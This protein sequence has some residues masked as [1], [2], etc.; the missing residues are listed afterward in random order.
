MLLAIASCGGEKPA[1]ELTFETQ[2]DTTGLS[3]GAPV[4]QEFEPYRMDNGAVRVK[5]R[6]RVPD[7][8]LLQIAIK[9]P[10]GVVSVAM[11]HV[12]VRGQWF[13]TPP[14]LEDTGPLP[15]GPYRFEL[16]SHFTPEWQGAE[17]DG[18]LRAGPSLRGPGITRAKDGAAALFLVKEGRL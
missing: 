4:V 17:G 9:E 10:D 16:L 14:L 6:V 8:T 12:R 5:G 11:A 18:A 15:T 7:G 13:D 2:P 3:E 1:T